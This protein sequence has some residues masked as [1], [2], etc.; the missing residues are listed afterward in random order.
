MSYTTEAPSDQIWQ[1]GNK[2]SLFGYLRYLCFK[3]LYLALVGR[4]EAPMPEVFAGL[5]APADPPSRNAG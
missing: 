4:P 1:S 3:A 2:F 5:A